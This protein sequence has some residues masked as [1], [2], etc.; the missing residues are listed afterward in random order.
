MDFGFTTQSKAGCHTRFMRNFFLVFGSLF[1][2][3]SGVMHLYFFKLESVDWLKPKTW[4]KFGLA[5][6]EHAEILRAMAYNQGFYNLFLALGVL[7]GSLL[8]SINTTVGFSL[9]IFSAT[10]MTLA[11][12]VLLLSVKNS[13]RAALIQALPPLF[14]ILFILLGFSFN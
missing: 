7:L 1:T 5:S 4:K 11:G 3:I 14:G 6:Q 2:G 8:L 9:I 10:S 13:K 12:L